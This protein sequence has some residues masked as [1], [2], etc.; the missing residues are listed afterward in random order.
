M[1]HV[2][3]IVTR[4]LIPPPSS[5]QRLEKG[6]ARMEKG[7]RF[8]RDYARILPLGCGKESGHPEEK[9]R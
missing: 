7:W 8:T 9:G 6:S 3:A 2:P 1:A 5:A 4:L